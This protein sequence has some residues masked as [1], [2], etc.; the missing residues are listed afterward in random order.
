[1]NILF[2]LIALALVATIISLVWGVGSMAAGGQFDDK[3]YTQFMTARVAFQG[4]TIVL[5]IIASI[6]SF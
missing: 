1:M 3:H 4:I 6:V 5:L 2:L